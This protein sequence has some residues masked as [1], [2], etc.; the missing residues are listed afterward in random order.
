MLDCRPLWT[1]GQLFLL[2]ILGFTLWLNLRSFTLVNSERSLSKPF[3]ALVDKEDAIGLSCQPKTHVGFLKTHKT[4]STTVY[5]ILA[6]MAIIKNIS[7][8]MF[9]QQNLLFCF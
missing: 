8:I 9:S 6:R 1:S 7:G 3:E 4:G 2:A 5:S